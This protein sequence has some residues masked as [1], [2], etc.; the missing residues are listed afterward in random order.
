MR[1]KDVA[2]VRRGERRRL[3]DGVRRALGR[4]LQVRHP[5]N[6]VG[7]HD[8]AASR[9]VAAARRGHAARV[10]RLQRVQLGGAAAR[11]AVEEEESERQ[12][13]DDA[14][15]REDGGED[16]S[17]RVPV[18]FLGLVLAIDAAVPARADAHAVHI[19]VAVARALDLLDIFARLEDPGVQPPL[20][21]PLLPSWLRE[22][23]RAQ[24]RLAS[25]TRVPKI[26]RQVFDCPAVG[27]A[28]DDGLVHPAGLELEDHHVLVR[29]PVF[30]VRQVR[31]ELKQRRRIEG[32][33][34]L[35]RLE[36]AR[37]LDGVCERTARRKGRRADVG[38]ELTSVRPLELPREL[39]RG[40]IGPSATPRE[41]GVPH[42]RLD[43]VLG[44]PRQRERSRRAE[45]RVDPALTQRGGGHHGEGRPAELLQCEHQPFA[46]AEVRAPDQQRHALVSERLQRLLD[47]V[48][49]LLADADREGGRD[50][51]D[52]REATR[53]ESHGHA[54]LLRDASAEGAHVTE[55]NLVRAAMKPA[56][57]LSRQVAPRQRGGI[58][59]QQRSRR[60]SQA[61]AASTMASTAVLMYRGEG[62]ST[63]KVRLFCEI[64]DGVAAV[65][66]SIMVL[67][68]Y[69]WRAA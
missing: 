18:L 35:V 13:G 61:S 68:A 27:H 14:R 40:E 7:N 69:D 28:G 36:R 34:H 4:R 31:K 12:E 9:L 6:R 11:S 55:V 58:P 62:G 59:R 42:H 8:R 41:R 29:L 21:R 3:D 24:R 51:C 5:H 22:E 54:G 30:V 25:P 63:P 10:G 23:H 66:A 16:Q 15:R 19:A 45:L 1:Q 33:G 56:L 17:A 57:R 50:G 26:D 60:L 48:D 32:G 52:E 44:R 37:A 67:S 38:D 53:V 49:V 39:D 47:V 20:A 65:V 43:G 46:G 2:L 64:T